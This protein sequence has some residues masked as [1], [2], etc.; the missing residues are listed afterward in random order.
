MGYNIN[1]KQV[2]ISTGYG[3]IATMEFASGNLLHSHGRWWI[4]VAFQ[5]VDFPVRYVKLPEINHD[6]LGNQD[7]YRTAE[8]LK[9]G[10]ID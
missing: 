8:T 6:A 10:C 4:T 7:A 5:Y 2:G 3:G 1:K 9:N